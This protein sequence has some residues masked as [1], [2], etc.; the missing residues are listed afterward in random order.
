MTVFIAIAVLLTLL[1]MAWIVRPLLRPAPAAGVSSERLNAS[2][3]RDQLDTLERDLARGVISPA[4]CEA[5]RDELQ[6]R[7]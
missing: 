4:D 1:V 7:L 5:T 6:L 3:Y 2:I